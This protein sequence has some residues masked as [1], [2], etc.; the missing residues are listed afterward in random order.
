MMAGSNTNNRGGYDDDGTITSRL[1]QHAQP[2]QQNSAS[3]SV[4][5]YCCGCKSRTATIIALVFLLL[6]GCLYTAV[7]IAGLNDLRQ[8]A[9]G[10]GYYSYDN[11]FTR[12]EDE[13]E[14]LIL[15]FVASIAILQVVVSIASIWGVCTYRVFPVKIALGLVTIGLIFGFSAMVLKLITEGLD[16]VFN[17]MFMFIGFAI[18]YYFI[19]LPLRGF[20]TEYSNNDAA[21]LLSIYQDPFGDEEEDE[22]AA[23]KMS[24]KNGGFSVVQQEED[25]TD[26]VE[27]V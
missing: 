10:E 24:T 27:M 21:T 5:L 19:F 14:R 1:Q 23:T 16:F 7:G 13:N 12:K 2:Q 8:R 11:Y 17:A 22:V 18:Q 26:A 9:E 15:R 25:I 4:K 20:V 6:G 3:S